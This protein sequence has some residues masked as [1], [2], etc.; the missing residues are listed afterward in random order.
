MS[1]TD[2]IPRKDS[3]LAPWAENFVTQVVANATAW[4]IPTSEVNELKT[5]LTDF[6][7]FYAKAES[8]A[9]SKIVVSQKNAK[10]KILKDK[11]RTMANFRLQNPIITDSQRV[12]LGLH[13]HDT[14]PSRIEPP[15]D[16][17]DLTLEIAGRR[18]VAA[19]FHSR[20]QESHARPYGVNGAVFAYG[21]L[22]APATNIEQLNRSLLATH[23]PYMMTF[24]DDERGHVLS[25]AACWQNE[26]GERGP[27]N[28]IQSTIIP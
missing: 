3:V 7:T 14:T 19:E 21:V 16:Q 11:I 8:P 13:V 5:A 2:Y 26:R 6:E 9:R 22:D 4:T 12:A 1:S 17:V 28:D 15:K 24:T 18:E 10:R 25:V 27:W 20:G 23:S